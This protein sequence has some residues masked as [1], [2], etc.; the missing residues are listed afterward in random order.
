MLEHSPIQTLLGLEIQ[1]EQPVAQPQEP[2]N[3]MMYSHLQFQP[4]DHIHL[5]CVHLEQILMRMPHYI[6]MHLA[7]PHLVE[8]QQIL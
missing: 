8:L 3:I 1:E 4:T 6:K 2:M 5:T 7:E